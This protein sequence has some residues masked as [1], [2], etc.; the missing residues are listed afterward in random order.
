[1]I[2]SREQGPYLSPRGSPGNVPD[3]RDTVA[4]ITTPQARCCPISGPQRACESRKQ[5]GIVA[6]P[7]LICVGRS[8]GKSM[9]L[10][11]AIKTSVEFKLPAYMAV[12]ALGI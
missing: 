6:L 4:H 1:M 12:L 3:M 11:A 8:E 5:G 7:F 2:G 10:R 9:R